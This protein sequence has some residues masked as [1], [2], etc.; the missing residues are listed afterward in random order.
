MGV[1]TFCSLTQTQGPPLQFQPTLNSLPSIATC[2]AL[3]RRIFNC[4][5]IWYFLMRHHHNIAGLLFS[6]MESFFSSLFS[7]TH[8]N[9]SSTSHPNPVASYCPIPVV[10]YFLIPLAAYC[11]NQVA[12]YHPDPKSSYCPIQPLCCP[13]QPSCSQELP[14][15]EKRRED[16]TEQGIFL[17]DQACLPVQVLPQRKQKLQKN[18]PFVDQVSCTLASC[19]HYSLPGNWYGFSLY[20]PLHEPITVKVYTSQEKTSPSPQAHHTTQARWKK[21]II[22]NALNACNFSQ[23]FKSLKIL[24]LLL[25]SFNIN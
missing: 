17:A 15:I 23:H 14:R 18:L 10:L 16:L 24:L 12:L 6:H 3:M 4:W 2:P 11:P 8:L 20:M 22:R 9:P 21:C 13:C 25:I 5:W 7:S 1:H 19:I